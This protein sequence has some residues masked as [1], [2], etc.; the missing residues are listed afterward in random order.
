MN[1]ET[2][3]TERIGQAGKKLHTGRSRNDQVATDVRLL[4]RA[5]IDALAQVLAAALVASQQQR[6]A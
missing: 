1:I 5:E 3:L 4:L 2:A 6:V